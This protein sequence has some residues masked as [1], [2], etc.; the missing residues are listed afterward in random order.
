MTL[1]TLN[2]GKNGTIV[3][4]GHAG[5]L[6]STE[7]IVYPPRLEVGFRVYHGA[8]RP[9]STKVGEEGLE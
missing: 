3:Y 9:P 8:R 5:F 1:S 2:L 6:V 7:P 4:L